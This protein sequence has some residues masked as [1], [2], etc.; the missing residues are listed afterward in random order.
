MYSIYDTYNTVLS[1]LL[2]LFCDRELNM[3]QLAAP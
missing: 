1:Q 3:W 2:F